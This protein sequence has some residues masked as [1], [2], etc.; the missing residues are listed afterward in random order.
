[1]NG[2]K[3]FDE[4][5][6]GGGLSPRHGNRPYLSFQVFKQNKESL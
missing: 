6:L 2:E 4:C 1:M 5:V 3:N